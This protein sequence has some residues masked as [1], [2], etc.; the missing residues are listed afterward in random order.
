[1]NATETTLD[2]VVL[3]ERI[4]E[5]AGRTIRFT[6]HG[7]DFRGELITVLDRGNGVPTDRRL[8][9]I[10]DGNKEAITGFRTRIAVEFRSTPAPAVEHNATDDAECTECG[11]WGTGNVPGCACDG[12][13]DGKAAARRR[14]PMPTVKYNGKVYKLRSRK[15][16][17]P[18]LAAMD[19]VPALMWLLR[20]TAPKGTNHRRPT[21]NLPNLPLTV[22]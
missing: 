14:G 11:H 19:S 6:S 12:C 7:V 13:D 5:F 4:S 9:V 18:D 15:T 2:A 10:M 8:T 22:R 17:I 21:P 20:N 16:E 3:M 1:M